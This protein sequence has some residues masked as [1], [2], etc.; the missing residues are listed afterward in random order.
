[1]C[2]LSNIEPIIRRLESVPRSTY[3]P[4]VIY[5]VFVDLLGLGLI[6]A[7]VYALAVSHMHGATPHDAHRF[8]QDFVR[9]SIAL[10]F[11]LT[12]I[13]IHLVRGWLLRLISDMRWVHF[14]RKYHLSDKE[15]DYDLPGGKG[16]M[17]ERTSKGSHLVLVRCYDGTLRILLVGQN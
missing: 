13:W 8:A 2:K 1:M 3:P 6:G 14:D 12:L 11:V 5:G 7:I 16:W 4:S 15:Q 9:S 10:M 17:L